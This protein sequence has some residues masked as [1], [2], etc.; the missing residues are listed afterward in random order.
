MSQHVPNKSL[1]C[2]SD[3]VSIYTFDS[4]DTN[5]TIDTGY[6]SPD[7]VMRGGGISHFLTATTGKGGGSNVKQLKDRTDT[8]TH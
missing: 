5:N 2:H 3:V 7:T 4:R 1:I 8:L 6:I